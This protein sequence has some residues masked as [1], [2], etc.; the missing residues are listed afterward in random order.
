[1]F[2][3]LIIFFS[4]LLIAELYF[5][6]FANYNEP[7]FDKKTKIIKREK[8]TEGVYKTD[9]VKTGYFRINNYG[10]NSFRDYEEEKNPETCR[11]AIVGHSNVEGLRVDVNQTFPALL[12]D[13]LIA[14]GKNAEV[15]TFGFGN[16]HLAQALHVSRHVVSKYDP[17]ILV[18]GTLLD[19]FF[20]EPGNDNNY[21]LSLNINS[22]GEIE[23]VSPVRSNNMENYSSIF[24]FLYFSKA[25]KYSDI[26]CGLGSKLKMRIGRNHKIIRNL[27]F[28]NS[29]NN[30]RLIMATDYL[31]SE[32]QKIQQANNIKIFFLN[33]PIAIPSYNSINSNYI[34]HFKEHRDKVIKQIEKYLFPVITLENSFTK[35]YKENEEK[36]DFPNDGHYNTRAHAVIA[37]TLTRYF[38]NYNIIN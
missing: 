34:N 18:I 21:F 32:F 5:R 11:I 13:K 14:N 28:C 12:N 6:L 38:L 31:L 15:Y 3:V 25:I 36:F 23:E 37:D 30:Q 9:F 10:W 29:S 26:R 20:Q 17:D 33:F 4:F 24:S 19:D 7:Y 8:N 27:K 1:M 22:K 35:D 2:I 16:M